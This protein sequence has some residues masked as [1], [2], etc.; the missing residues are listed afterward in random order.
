ML[1]RS[2]RALIAIAWCWLNTYFVSLKYEEIEALEA[3]ALQEHFARSMRFMIREK[4]SKKKKPRRIRA[5]SYHSLA[6]RRYKTRMKWK[7]SAVV[8]TYVAMG[9]K[10][11]LTNIRA[12]LTSS[13]GAN[14]VCTE[15]CNSVFRSATSA[16]AFNNMPL[17]CPRSL[18]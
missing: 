5:L 8:S 9:R 6:D 1:S 4:S 7:S 11:R 17:E 15:I 2:R 16:E 13:S 10:I 18:K 3:D 14:V 12:K